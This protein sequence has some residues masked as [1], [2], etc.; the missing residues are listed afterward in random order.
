[1]KDLRINL[2]TKSRVSTVD[3]NN[4]PFGKIISDHMFEIDFDGKQW[5][6]PRIQPVANL[7]MHPMNMALHYG[8]SIF[9]GMKAFRMNDGS[10]NIIRR[11][12]FRCETD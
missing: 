9:E 2:V 10:I 5:I 12:A 8:Q 7:S 11:K 1:M 4:L 6:N 3:F